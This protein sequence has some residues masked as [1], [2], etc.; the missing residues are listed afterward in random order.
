MAII[1]K[2]VIEDGSLMGMVAAKGDAVRA[3]FVVGMRREKIAASHKSEA[4]LKL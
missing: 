1:S 4:I 3:L 2:T